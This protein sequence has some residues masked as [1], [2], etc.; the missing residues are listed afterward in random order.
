MLR[1]PDLHMSGNTQLVLGAT[2]CVWAIGVIIR[3]YR[4]R[5]YL[6]PSPPTRRLRGHFLPLQNASL[7]VVWWIDEY[8]PLITIRSGLRTT[9]IIDRYKAAVD[10]MEK[11]GKLVA[12]RPR[13]AAGEIVTRGLSIILARAGD[14]FRRSRRA[15]QSHLQPKSA[16]EYQPLQMSQ[17]KNMILNLLDD[18]DNFQNHATTYAAS[19][20]LKVAYGKTTPTS[21]TDPEIREARKLTRRLRTILRHGHYLVDSIPWLKYLPGYAPELQDEFER[22]K[23]LYTGQL[24]R[25]KLQM[26][27]EDIGPSFAK[28]ILENEHLYG[29]TEIQMAYLAGAFFGAGTETTAMAICTVLMAA[30]HFPEE[31]ARV[32]D[33]LDEVI[34]RKRAPTFTDRSSLPRLEAFIPGVPR[35]TT[36][37]ENYCIPAGTTIVG[38]HWAISRDPEVYPEPNAFKPQ[39]WIDGQGRLRNNLAFFVFGF[40]RRVCPGQHVAHRSVFINSVLILW[41][42]QLSLDHTKPQDDTGF[43]NV[44]MPNIPC[45]IKFKTRIPEVELRH[46]MQ[47]YP[48]AG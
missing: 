45:A 2:V 40:G 8:G 24:N 47:N 39:R 12:D 3:A 20:I 43:T 37:D 6:P 36:Q 28:Y 11:Q 19:T 15:L 26:N 34:G 35:R 4:R 30:T 44:A 25:V 22:T 17:A 48:E 31:Q 29:F 27:N 42:F 23:R 18:P 13:L 1:L 46:M 33:E 10:I 32:Q 38:N 16:E 41:A 14:R 21:A 7:T 5:S 9:V